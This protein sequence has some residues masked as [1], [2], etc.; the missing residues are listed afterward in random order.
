MRRRFSNLVPRAFSRPFPGDELGGSGL[1][2]QQGQV[3]KAL[4]LQSRGPEFNS[5]PNRQLNLFSVVL[6]SNPRSRLKNS[7][8]VFFRSVGILINLLTFTFKC[9][10]LSLFV[11]HNKNYWVTSNCVTPT[12]SF[13]WGEGGALV[14]LHFLV[15]RIVN[16][17]K[18]RRA[19]WS[20]LL[21]YETLLG[22]LYSTIVKPG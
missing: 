9:L 14:F 3:D 17:Q 18:N 6:S 12:T 13:F 5:C 1:R 8:L 21:R 11:N 10:F 20:T 22:S 2:R 7:R 19:N 16:K 15:S 4:E